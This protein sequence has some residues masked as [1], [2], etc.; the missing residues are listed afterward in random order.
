M[1]R[2]DHQ[3][4][5]IKRICIKGQRRNTVRSSALTMNIIASKLLNE[6]PYESFF[7]ARGNI[8]N[9]EIFTKFCPSYKKACVQE[10]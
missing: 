6:K 9:A 1:R 8:E 5:K 2:V 10:R 4:G 7:F 3:Q